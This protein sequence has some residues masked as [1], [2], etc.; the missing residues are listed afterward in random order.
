MSST[1]TCSSKN[2]THTFSVKAA[3][4][5]VCANPEKENVYDLASVYKLFSYLHNETGPAI[6]RNKDGY[7]EFWID[8]DRV[9]KEQ[10]EAMMHNHSFQKKLSEELD[11]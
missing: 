8:G 5:D 4:R 9:P 11:K 7:Q 10:S 2:N 1:Y 6:T 3:F